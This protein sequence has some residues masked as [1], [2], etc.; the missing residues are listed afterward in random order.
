MTI[1]AKDKA[2]QRNNR[3]NNNTSNNSRS[4]SKVIRAF[5]RSLFTPSPPRPKWTNL[6]QNQ[7]FTP[8]ETF[9]P[10]TYEELV[11]IV[12]MAKGANKKIR[13]AGSG[14]TWSSS[15]VVEN[16]Y[17]VIVNDMKKIHAP[18]YS[19]EFKSWTVTVE[20]GVLVKDLDDLLRKHDPPLALPSNVVL[21]SHGAATRT[22]TLP[23]LVTEVTIIDADGKLNT[24]SEAKNPEEFAAATINLGLFGVIYT[25]THFELN[26][27]SNST[28]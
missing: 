7:S 9:H 23:D 8:C 13:C 2:A 11:A 12:V 14:H 1:Q 21:D 17:L 5:F 15:S 22:R 19:N 25:Y 16:G 20:T 24:F 28:W 26:P 10:A 6:A 18:V 27:C 3:S 4:K